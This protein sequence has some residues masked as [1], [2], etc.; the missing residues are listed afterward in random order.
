LAGVSFVLLSTA[1][2]LAPLPFGSNDPPYVAL[3]CIVLGTALVFADPRSLRAAQLALLG[4][5]A[6]VFG[7]YA[8]VLHEQLAEHPWTGAAP[9]E[10]WSTAAGLLERPILPS[11]S[12]ARNQPWFSLGAPLAAVS[13]LVCSFV[14]CADRDRARRLLWV[15]AWSGAAYAVFAV[16]ELLIDPN[17]VLWRDKPQYQG[18]L[19]GTFMNRNTAA[20]YFGICAIVWLLLVA[21]KVRALAPHEHRIVWST[22]LRDILR[23]PSR[24][25]VLR[26]S[27][28]FMC[29]AAMSLTGSRAG[30]VLSLGAMIAAFWSYFR[31][32]IPRGKGAVI[33]AAIALTVAIVVLQVL[34]AGVSSRLGSEGAADGGRRIAYALTARMAED[35]PWLGTGLGTFVWNFPA[36]RTADLPITGIW[37]RAHDTWLELAS[38]LGIPLTGLI[39]AGW[40]LIIL[41]LSRGVLYRR[42]DLVVPAAGLSAALLA[43]AHSSV[44][45]S[46]QTPGFAIVAVAVVGAGLAQSFRSKS[47]ERPSAERVKRIKSSDVNSVRS[48]KT[49]EE[50]VLPK[51]F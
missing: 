31:R 23:K 25:L 38:D 36:Y 49:G 32:D 34:G 1:V 43:V 19:T 2:V 26:F 11:V 20:A 47:P 5:A 39:V 13:A 6:I 51:Q 12:I 42:R 44:D 22:L 33:G 3:L 40:M 7:A 50:T 30:V 8:F 48:V 10:L 4:L 46:L 16:C 41:V 37:D 18:F 27:M 15:I 29:V 35:H 45:F 21:E 28:L 17:K 9:H 24:R 14:V